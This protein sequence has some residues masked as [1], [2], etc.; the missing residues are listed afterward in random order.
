MATIIDLLRHLGQNAAPDGGNALAGPIT[1]PS[2]VEAP[3][4]LPVSPALARAWSQ[5]TRRVTHGYHALALSAT[6]AGE[7]I[8]LMGPGA[9]AH[10]DLLLPLFQQLLAQPRRAALY[11]LPDEPARAPVVEFARAAGVSVADVAT[12][13]RAT[14]ARLL[15]ATAEDLHRRVLRYHDR[16]WRWLWPRLDTLALPALHRWN[17]AAAGHL[18]WLIRR[19]ERLTPHAPLQIMASLAPVADAEDG[20]RRLIDRPCRVIAAPD[21]A[22]HATLIALWRCGADRAAALRNLYRRLRARQLAVAVLGRDD[23]ETERLRAALADADPPLSLAESRIALVAGVPASPVARRTLARLGQRLV[24][25]LAGEEPHELLFAAE[26]DLL[27]ESLVWWPL[28]LHNPYIGAA[29]LACAASEAPLRAADIDRWQARDLRD[30]LARKGT[31]RALPDAELWQPGPDANCDD[32]DPATVGGVASAVVD[33]DGQVIDRVPSALLDRCALP[34]QMWDA[35]RRVAGRDDG[36]ALVKLAPDPDRR[37]TLPVARIDVR[38]REEL[39]ARSFQ[40]G[41]ATLEIVRGKVM[42]THQATGVLEYR[43][44][45]RPRERALPVSETQWAAAACWLALPDPPLDDRAAGWS[46]TG[47]LPLLALARPASLLV[48]YDSHA[49]RLYL[50]EAEPGGVGLIDRCYQHPQRLF[51]LALRLARACC[52]H[53]LYRPLAEAEL[54]WLESLCQPRESVA[55][56]SATSDDTALRSDQPAAVTHAGTPAEEARRPVTHNGASE[57]QESQ[58]RSHRILHSVSTTARSPRARMYEAR[59][60]GAPSPEIAAIA[61]TQ[62]TAQSEPAAAAERGMAPKID[63]IAMEEETPANDAVVSAEVMS[64]MAQR[65][66]NDIDARAASGAG[67]GTA[68]APADPEAATREPAERAAEAAP[69]PA[70]WQASINDLLPPLPEDEERPVPAPPQKHGSSR[71]PWRVRHATRPRERSQPP[72]RPQQ[73]PVQPQPDQPP[74]R[75]DRES[76]RPEELETPV[77]VN[78]LIARMRQLRAQR[79]GAA[80]ATQPA[81]ARSARETDA[82]EL[83]FHIGERVQCLPYGVG[84]VRSSRVVDGREQLVVAFPEYGEIDIDPSVSLVRAIGA[85][86]GTQDASSGVTDSDDQAFAG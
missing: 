22:P 39:G 15:I 71:E 12:G 42:V 1:L 70:R 34:G 3:L 63:D 64:N 36:A 52:N 30:H 35:G 72:S 8:A 10:D 37:V 79:E 11:L 86:R 56:A 59:E 60:E 84:I 41:P 77:D 69:A 66:R 57:D 82:V 29:H 51:D 58:V 44:G 48:T 46:L 2:V 83:R 33:P 14:Q 25:M 40:H 27:H 43:A 50:I 81:P 16:A 31:L 28:G 13:A 21:G 26:P 65:E 45:E 53:P 55:A 80:P 19:V 49:R 85:T 73:R 67:D 7:S 20:L 32:L 61:E 62:T 68:H 4:P 74:R 24:I 76:L 17:G 47:A 23:H 78:A 9:A 18:F 5:Q 54:A 75:E 38:V 6:Q